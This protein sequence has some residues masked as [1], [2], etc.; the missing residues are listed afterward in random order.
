MSLRCCLFEKTRLRPVAFS[1]R[2]KIP[3]ISIQP[4]LISSEKYQQQAEDAERKKTTCEE[5]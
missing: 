5:K 2:Q 4:I 3:V 1:E